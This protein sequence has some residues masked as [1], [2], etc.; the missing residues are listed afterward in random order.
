[1]QSSFLF[2]LIA[3]AVCV[4]CRKSE[5]KPMAD[6]LPTW[7]R[8]HYQHGDGRAL[9]YY[10]VYGVFTNDVT[11]SGSKYRTAG[12]PNGF[13]LDK[14]DRNRHG[15][16]ENGTVVHKRMILPVLAA[17]VDAGR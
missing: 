12:L 2:F 15:P 17:G 6:S 5:P 10:A 16:N 13:V 14:L 4:G 11:I 9:I 3:M 7:K 8:D 1:M